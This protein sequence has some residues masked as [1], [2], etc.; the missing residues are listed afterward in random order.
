VAATL[1]KIQAN[2]RLAGYRV[3]ENTAI[4]DRTYAANAAHAALLAADRLNPAHPQHATTVGNVFFIADG[5]PR[6]YWDYMGTLWAAAG[7]AQ[8]APFPVGKGTAKFIMGVKDVMQM[9]R[10]EKADGWKKVEFTSANRTYDITLAREVLDYTPI[11]SYDEGIRR[12]AEVGFG[13]VVVA[14][15]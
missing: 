4:V 12:V 9:L 8:A 3:G 2:P 11:V 13:F 15:A 14:P 6:P 1:R 7:G 5:E 10:G